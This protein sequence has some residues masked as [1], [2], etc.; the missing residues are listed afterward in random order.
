MVDFENLQKYLKTDLAVL[1]FRH[2][3]QHD[4]KKCDTQHKD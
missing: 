4:N 2:E 1:N 3:T